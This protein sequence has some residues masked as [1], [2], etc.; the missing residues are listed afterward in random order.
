MKFWMHNEGGASARVLVRFVVCSAFAVHLIAWAPLAAAQSVDQY[1]RTLTVSA[2]DPVTLEVDVPK[3]ELQILYGREGQV[4]V[5]A[6]PQS[7]G[8]ASPHKNFDG[9]ITLVQNGNDI[10]LADVSNFQYPGVGVLYRIDVPYRTVITSTINNGNLTIS[11][12]MGPVKAKTG[13]GDIKVSYVSKELVAQ[14]GSGN[15]DLQ[16]IGGRVEASAESG[17][18]S[19]SRAALGVS[20]ETQDGDITLMEVG[21]STAIVKKGSGRINVGGIRGSFLG[22]ADTGDVRVKAVPYSDWQ[23]GSRTGTVRVALPRAAK[24]EVEAASTSGEISV[25]RND[26][27][28]PNDVHHLHQAVNGGGT[29][30]QLSTES[31][32]IVIQ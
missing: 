21:S 17:S 15:L 27:S 9:G 3:G 20:A 10:K 28:R 11:G 18:I 12:V 2:N 23:L 19:C 8:K 6:V 1:H 24:F 26:T 32:R 29:R 22:T 4:S 7:S 13:R 5:S 16:V 30:I 14:A 25:E 31:G